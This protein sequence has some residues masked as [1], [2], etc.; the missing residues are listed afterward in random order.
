MPAKSQQRVEEP[1]PA[2][3]QAVAA[4]AA[5]V[6]VR[7]WT[8]P[9][10]A[11][12]E[13]LTFADPRLQ[14]GNSGRAAAAL[15]RSAQR[16]QGNAWLAQGGLQR[17]P[18]KIQTKRTS[19]APG[20]V[21]EQ[22]ADHVAE[23]VMRMPNSQPQA[24]C[25][26]GGECAQCQMGQ[27]GE[28][29]EHPRAEQVQA[30]DG[31]DGAIPP[32]VHEV[33]RSPG[34]PLD[35]S[36]RAFME[37]RFGHDFSHVRVHT[38]AQAAKSAQAVSA[39]AYT[40]GH[41]IVFAEGEYSPEI[42]G[43]RQLLA[44]ELTHVVQQ[45]AGRMARLQRQGGQEARPAS[46]IDSR[47]DDPNFLLCVALCYIG[48]PPG[49]WRTVVN[50]VLEAVSSEYRETRGEVRGSQE[51]EQWRA[52]FQTWSAFNKFK[53]VI[54]FL[55]ESRIGPIVVRA[56]AAQAIRERALAFVARAGIRSGSLAVASQIIRKVAIFL[57]LAWA[58]GCASYCGGIAYANAII[59]FST[60]A[61]SA[62][63]SFT[64]LAG[65]VGSGILTQLI[66]RPVLIARAT[67][68]P[69]NWDTS[70][71]PSASLV[72]SLLGNSLW[73][74]LQTNDSNTFLANI[75][76]PMSSFRIPRSVIEEIATQMT[77]AVSARG[78]FQVTFTPELILGLTPL[79]FVQL[80][81]DWRLLRFTRDPEQIADEA[82]RSQPATP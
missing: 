23:Q 6:P 67:M 65:Q 22:Q 58:A 42:S 56:A 5:P 4:P 9:A 41:D 44:H 27:Q 3:P 54:G 59:D 21:S 76:R 7:P 53:L 43:G 16:Y 11:A 57:E 68:D 72:L 34:Q 52:E 40:V 8:S 74:Q 37:P 45:G 48:L 69:S 13:P 17:T 60:S 26:C 64:R 18:I 75:A 10:G 33:L 14:H 29:H 31:G 30:S 19:D 51:F 50:E 32:G 66:A 82:L 12:C 70:V 63:A 15:L 55:G 28:E 35:A 2:R 61:V 71:M 25:L 20:D 80:L 62:I 49:L 38:G 1:V 78:G 39:R 24:A 81:K 79:T 46:Q 77:N 47:A 36:T 73:S